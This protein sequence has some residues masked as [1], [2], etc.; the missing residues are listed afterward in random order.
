[1]VEGSDKE[2]LNGSCPR[3][4]VVGRIVLGT[5]DKLIRGGPIRGVGF[6]SKIAPS[7]KLPELSNL[8]PYSRIY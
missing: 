1:M 4:I 7:Q 2:T 5:L 8:G 3:Y 6:G